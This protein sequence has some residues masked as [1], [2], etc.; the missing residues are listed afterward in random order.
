MDKQK[1]KKVLVSVIVVCAVILLCATGYILIKSLGIFSAGNTNKKVQES[2]APDLTAGMTAPDGHPLVIPSIQPQTG[3]TGTTGATVPPT[4]TSGGATTIITTTNNP[5]DF[6]GLMAYNP[7]VYAWIYIPDTNISLPVLQS[8]QD[9][10]FYL[11]HDVYKDYSFP[12]AIYSQSKNN[13]EFTDRV[14]VLY[15]HNMND[16]S[17]FADLH[18][19]GD[20]DFFHSHPYFYVFTKDRRLTYEVVSAHDYDDRHILNSYNFTDDK[21][22]QEWLTNAKEPRSLYSNVRDSVKLDLNSKMLVLSTC[23]GS[24]DGRYLV[25]G[26]LIGDEKTK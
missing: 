16:G 20:E 4:T 17:M 8:P 14:T 21:V 3:A 6:E 19:F 9:D 13:R 23:T 2:F 26:V 22:F 12:G 18:M 7:D 11:D 24:G 25:Q 15:G 5:V 10:N 1:K